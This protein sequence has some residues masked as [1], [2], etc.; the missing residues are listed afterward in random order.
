MSK[1]VLVFAGTSEGKEIA[2]FLC[3]NNVDTTAVTATEYGEVCLEE[4][5]NLQTLCGRMSIEDMQSEVKKYD[6]IVDATHPYAQVV[7]QNISLACENAGVFCIRVVRENCSTQQSENVLRFDN[8]HTACE[9]LNT[10]NGN[11]LATT[12]SKELEPY[13]LIANYKERVFLRVLPVC[14]SIAQC[15]ESGFAT[16]KLIA[17]KGPFDEQMNTAMI[18]STKAAFV[19]TKDT[20]KTGGFNEKLSAAIKTGVKLIIINRPKDDVGLNKKQA[21]E[22]LAQ[23]CGFY[24]VDS[25]EKIKNKND[26]TLD[27]LKQKKTHFPLFF[28]LFGKNILFVGGGNISKRRIK[29]LLNFGAVIRVVAPKI[30]NEILQLLG[31]EQCENKSF[32]VKDLENTDIVFC[33]TNDKAINENIAEKCREKSILVNVCDNHNLCDFYFPALIESDEI[34]GGI[35]SKNGKN[36]KLVKQKAQN[37]RDV[38]K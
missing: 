32:E 13:K 8:L 11:I 22:K 29:T 17:M 30:E 16:S 3:E 19:V 23:F 12:G 36:H 15:E 9:F 35:I 25:T 34:I 20:G 27:L 14:A 4:I 6:V 37:I 2:T 7:S 1:R 18:N 10:Q 24:Y 21:F 38:L 31:N 26:N 5:S 33:T 28:D